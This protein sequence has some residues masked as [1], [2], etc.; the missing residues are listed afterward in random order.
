MGEE[1]RREEKGRGRGRGQWGLGLEAGEEAREG[2]DSGM[3]KNR[4]TGE[5]WAGE[6]WGPGFKS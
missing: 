5:R 3:R 1:G 2:G 4:L 6:C